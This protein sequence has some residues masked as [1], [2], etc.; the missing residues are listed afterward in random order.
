MRTN[1]F[2]AAA[3]LALLFA[4]S[5]PSFAQ[6]PAVPPANPNPPV[7]DDERLICIG[8][9]AGANVYTT[10][11]YIGGVADAYA[12]QAYPAEKVQELMKEVVGLA[13]VSMRQLKKVRDG[14]IV[15]SDKKV[16]DEVVLV[17]ELLQREAQALSAYTRTKD[18]SDLKDFEKAR[19]DVW[20]KIKLVL[21]IDNAAPA[22]A[23]AAPPAP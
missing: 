2:S 7:K 15:D 5:L 10:Y 3:A 16:I 13:D 18:P 22:E 8:A 19:T 11:G 20:P 21:G 17:Y 14:N 23:P 12:H 1:W 6:A 4:A 9:L